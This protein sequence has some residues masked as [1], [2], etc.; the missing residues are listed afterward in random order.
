[1]ALKYDV[2]LSGVMSVAPVQSGVT[3]ADVKS[4]FFAAQAVHEVHVTDRAMAFSDSLDKLETKSDGETVAELEN[5]KGSPAVT[6]E[7]RQEGIRLPYWAFVVWL[8][9]P[10]AASIILAIVLVKK[11]KQVEYLRLAMSNLYR[12]TETKISIPKTEED[13]EVLSADIPNPPKARPLDE[14]SSV[15]GNP[16]DP[17]SWNP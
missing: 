9:V 2:V 6:A 16:I 5:A 17:K 13:T 1:M 10:L 15:I 4:R 11:Q 12:V 3:L 14:P 7:A 8:V